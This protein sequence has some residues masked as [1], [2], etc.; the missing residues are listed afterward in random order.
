MS[1]ALPRRPPPRRAPRAGATIERG[2]ALEQSPDGGHV[3]DD[4]GV[5]EERLEVLRCGRPRGAGTG[6]RALVAAVAVASLASA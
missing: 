5:L 1:T 6:H 4:A 3:L 2:V